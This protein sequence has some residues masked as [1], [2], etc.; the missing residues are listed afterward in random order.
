MSDIRS[1]VNDIHKEFK[2]AIINPAF[3]DPFKDPKPGSSKQPDIQS[4]EPKPPPKTPKGKGIGKKT[5]PLRPTESK[6]VRKIK[7]IG[8]K[9]SDLPKDAQEK[10]KNAFSKNNAAN[11]DIEMKNIQP[12]QFKPPSAPDKIPGITPGTSTV[13]SKIS[14][15][16]VGTLLKTGIGAAVGAAGVGSIAG[17]GA[18][19]G[20]VGGSIAAIAGGAA[21]G[22]ALGS[23]VA[24]IVEAS[25]GDATAPGYKYLGPGN[26]LDK[27]EPNSAV[28]ADAKIHDE[29]YS[30]AKDVDDVISADNDF[31]DK[32]NDHIVDGINTL[33][34]PSD[35][36]AAVVG[37]GVIGVK[38]GIQ[39]LSGSVIYPNVAPPRKNVNL[40]ISKP[41]MSKAVSSSGQHPAAGTI[42]EAPPAKKAKT[43]SA[44][45]APA[46]DGSATASGS[47]M[48]NTVLPGTG[49]ATADGG[50]NADGHELYEIE[51]PI[52]HFGEQLNVYGKQHKFMTFGL[53]NEV[54]VGN[55]PL[56]NMRLLTTSLAEIPWH[57]LPLFL[58]L[59]E[60]QLLPL[61]S[62]V[63]EVNVRVVFRGVRI[64]FET[65]ASTAGLATLN[66]ICNLQTAVGLN[67]LGWGL[68]RYFTTFGDGQQ[69]MSPR[70]YSTPRYSAVADGNTILYRGMHRDYYGV[71][72]NNEEFGN[73]GWY[74]HHQVGS[75]TF[76]RNYFC[77]ASN[78][79]ISTG[80]I[81]GWPCLT[82]HI[83][84]Y[85]AK[86]VVNTEIMNESYKPREGIIK[87]PKM[88]LKNIGAP[89]ATSNNAVNLDI[90]GSFIAPRTQSSGFTVSGG[91]PNISL[92][93]GSNVKATGNILPA[94]N[95]DGYYMDIE[96]SQWVSRGL[97]IPER[98]E[99]QPS[100]HV[101]IQAVPALTTA[102][103]AGTMSNWT[104][105]MAYFDVYASCVIKSNTPTKFPYAPVPNVPVEESVFRINAS[106]PLA[107]STVSSFHHLYPTHANVL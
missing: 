51:R 15:D 22:T 54:L 62:E 11:N 94:D 2:N 40:S 106:V 59:S 71:E 73:N 20:P 61:G 100:L 34:N 56:P 39:K 75:F 48:S 9:L 1:L 42:P 32:M 7:K 4:K 44:A 14:A 89:T 33:N 76:L 50:A 17:A 16:A 58:N 38:N 83:N 87:N 80:A 104:D 65:S 12:K 29:Q 97:T 93:E 78:T 26:D 72:N 88:W 28:D 92:T 24:G 82:E 18:T 74:P 63:V 36:V 19:L 86:T 3:K 90:G 79:E 31:V 37:S 107:N 52:S 49:G 10:I 103:L 21:V 8:K 96:K 91:V 101:G 69:S 66:Q 5:K 99:I 77:L 13:G 68:E 85:D 47:T 30:Q 46:S 105:S 84:Q 41:T 43:S 95:V 23:A 53:S 55:N 81:G 35:T 25:K 102:N 70:S 64:A 98:G 45:T 27:G 57:K 67:K 6:P 60:Y